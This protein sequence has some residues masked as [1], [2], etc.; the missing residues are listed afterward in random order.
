[1]DSFILSVETNDNF[2]ILQDSLL[3]FDSCNY[4]SNHPCFSL[5][6]KAITSL[7]K[8]KLIKG[9]CFKIHF[10]MPKGICVVDRNKNEKQCGKTMQ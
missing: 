8:N 1:M 5:N 3:Y 10:P 4:C 2:P 9:L 6:Q 7:F